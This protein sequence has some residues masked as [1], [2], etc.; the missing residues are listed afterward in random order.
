MT[1]EDEH[2]VFSSMTIASVKQN[3]IRAGIGGRGAGIMETLNL[4]CLEPVPPPPPKNGE[5][6]KISFEKNERNIL[7]FYYIIIGFNKQT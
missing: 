6:H 1:G 5:G 7:V 4:G 2:R 3:Y